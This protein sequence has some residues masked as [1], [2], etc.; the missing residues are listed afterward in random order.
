MVFLGED[1]KTKKQLHWEE[2]PEKKDFLSWASTITDLKIVGPLQEK[3]TQLLEK[4]L[5][6]IH[7]RFFERREPKVHRRAPFYV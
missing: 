3:S 1:P 2:D 6:L 4:G 7:F 5:S